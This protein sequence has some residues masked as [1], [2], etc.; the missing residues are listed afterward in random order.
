[1]IDLSKIFIIGKDLTIEERKI[2]KVEYL[3]KVTGTKTPKTYFSAFKGW[4]LIFNS[5]PS[6]KC[7]VRGKYEMWFMIEFFNLL[8]DYLKNSY[9]HNA[10]QKT[11]INLGN[12]VE[13]IGPRTLL[14]ER[15]KTFLESISN[16]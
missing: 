7:Y 6:Y 11:F 10:K 3:E 8:K 13:V 16:N 1:M 15:L 5:L 14:P 12:G 4:Y 9:G 2:D